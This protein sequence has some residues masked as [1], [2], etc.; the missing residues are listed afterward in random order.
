MH[1]QSITLPRQALNIEGQ[2]FTLLTAI[3]PVDMQAHAVVWL[4]RCECGNET[5]VLISRLRNGNTRSC[6]CLARPKTHGMTQTAIYKIWVQINYRCTNQNCP[7]YPSYGGRGIFCCP[8]W[9][10]SFESFYAHVNQLPHFGEKGYSLDRIDNDGGYE[11]SNV[12]WAT[13]KN[14]GRNRRTNHLVTYHEETLTVTEWAE[15]L[16]MKPRTLFSRLFTMKW[17]I[18]RAFM[19]QV[20]LHRK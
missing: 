1:P 17:D 11:P 12:R 7:E 19:Q 15:R 6:G 8:Q 4:C 9:R 16:N 20:K 13:W 2:K 5:R 18:E 3:A 14:Q 10:D